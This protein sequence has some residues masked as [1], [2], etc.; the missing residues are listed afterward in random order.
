MSPQ[1]ARLVLSCS[2]ASSLLWLAACNSDDNSPPDFTP[3]AYEYGLVTGD[4]NN[5]G[6]V[7]VLSASTL[8]R[9]H[10]PY[11][12]GTLHVHLHDGDATAGFATAV[13]Y[14]AGDEPLYLA[15]ADL[16]G[17]GLPD[18]VSASYVDGDIKVFLNQSSAPGT[19]A[20]PVSL[21]SS[22]ASQVVIA[23][24]NGDGLPDIVSADFNVSLFIQD[25][26]NPGTFLAP[27]GLSSGGANWVAVGDLNHD[28]MPDIV[29]VD[30]SGVKVFFHT[31]AASSTTYSAA[32]TVFTQS[33][34]F[35]LPGASLVAIGDVNADG[36][37]DLVITDPG[38]TGGASPS[39]NVLLQ[40]SST[41]GTFAAPVSYPIAVQNRAY[42]IVL[43]DLNADGRPDIAIGESSVVSV[44][45]QSSSTL[46]SYLPVTSYATPVGAFQ[47]GVADVN[48]DGAVDIVTT[49]STDQPLSGGQYTTRSGVLLQNAASA[50]SFNA[51]ADLP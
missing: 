19:F 17:D 48:G 16:N 32:T 31:G 24:L 50:G 22:G 46:G 11:Y 13:D 7:D 43:T 33:V 23:D 28:G 18:V 14:S 27:L 30:G 25:A 20:T 51:L 4:F 1:P 21:P 26:S 42:S 12:D 36:Y 39:V 8:Y 41:P 15:S 34:N 29:V 3:Y 49:N 44:L 47:I 35:N 2:M 37:E 38:P 6:V 5:D 45:L 9:P 40:D 10:S